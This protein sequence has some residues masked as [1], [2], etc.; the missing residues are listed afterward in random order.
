MS[1]SAHKKLAREITE[2]ITSGEHPI[3]SLLPTE[4]QLCVKH[5]LS[6]Y[7]VRKALDELQDLGL[8]SRRKN[9]GSRVQAVRPAIPFTQSIA[10]VDEL[11]QFGATHERVVRSIEWLVADLDLAREIGCMGGTKWI[12]LS[13]LRMDAP[14]KLHPICWTDVYV[15]A[16]FSEIGKLARESPNKL[17]SSLIEARYSRPIVRIQQD[18]AAI[19]TP[20]AVAAELQTEVGTPALKIKRRY[21]DASGELIEVSTS[22]HPANRFV[23]SME[24]SRT[25]N[26]ANSESERRVSLSR[27]A[28][29]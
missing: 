26:Q 5:G 18:I 12:R 28:T 11:T 29:R 22:I 27:I 6:R 25:K 4:H 23:F 7:A 1:K 17:I 13:S 15:D 21:F 9:V 8:I 10:T 20:A 19:L 16:A 14:P 24:I 3:G 2:G